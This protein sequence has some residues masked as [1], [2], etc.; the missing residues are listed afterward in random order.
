[1]T[2]TPPSA[3]PKEGRTKGAG[4]FSGFAHRDH[5]GAA[6]LKGGKGKGGWH[7]TGAPWSAAPALRTEVL[8]A[9]EVFKGTLVKGD[10]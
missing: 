10:R 8:V 6:E 5:C 1:L 4:T 3:G 9:E 7:P 2:I